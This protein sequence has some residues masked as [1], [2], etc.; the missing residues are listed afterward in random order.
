MRKIIMSIVMLISTL[1]IASVPAMAEIGDVYDDGFMK[2]DSVG[3]VFVTSITASG[4]VAIGST[5]SIS[6]YANVKTTLDAIV[7]STGVLSR[8]TTGY[9]LVNA[10]LPLTGGTLT[11]TLTGTTISVATITAP[12]GSFALPVKTRSAAVVITPSPGMMFFNSTDGLI[13]QATGTVVDG[14]GKV[15][16]PTAGP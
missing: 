8:Q 7:V 10:V 16:D 6:G 13:Y 14:W 2:V 4:Y 11:G 15:A 3:H 9:A 5:L 1:L 12:S